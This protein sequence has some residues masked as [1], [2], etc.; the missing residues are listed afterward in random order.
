MIGKLIVLLAIMAALWAIPASRE[1]MVVLAVPVLEKLGPTGERLLVP[2]H[3]WAARHDLDEVLNGMKRDALEGRRPPDPQSFP[4]YA[5]RQLED[6]GLDPWGEP[7]WL[8][9]TGRE[10]TVGSSGPDSRRGSEDDITKSAA[11]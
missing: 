9:R 3:R 11:F 6:D 8:E 5:R 1:R 7:Y 4:A 10:V 2:A